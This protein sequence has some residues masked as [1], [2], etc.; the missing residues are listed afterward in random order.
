MDIACILPLAEVVD[1]V[2]FSGSGC[3][4]DI[5][6]DG[7]VMVA[8]ESGELSRARGDE[9]FRFSPLNVAVDCSATPSFCWEPDLAS[10][11][12]ASS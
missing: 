10:S 9:A 7:L 11:G 8:P 4:F 1:E 5:D 12:T 3:G 6:S 2:V